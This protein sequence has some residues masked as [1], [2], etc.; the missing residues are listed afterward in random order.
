MLKEETNN[1]VE[2]QKRW[3][4][5]I[6]ENYLK[7]NKVFIDK[8]AIETI[9]ALGEDYVRLLQSRIIDFSESQEKSKAFPLGEKE[10]MVIL[11]KEEEPRKENEKVR[12]L[13][14]GNGKS[15]SDLSRDIADILKDKNILFYRPNSNQIVEVGKIKLHNKNENFYLGFRV[16]K[17][18]RFITLIEKYANVGIM[19]KGKFGEF[20]MTKS[21]SSI[22]ADIVLCSEIIEQALPQIE[23]VFSIPIPIMY[24]GEL[25]F[26]KKG[27]DER[28]NSWMNHNTPEINQDLDLEEA[29]KII[30]KV[31]SEFCFLTNQDK[32]NAIAG[33]LTPFLRGLFESFNTRTP[34][35]FFIANRE[36]IGKDYCAGVTGIVYD[37]QAIDDTPISSG[38]KYGGNNNEELR[39]KI[40]SALLSG[41][42]RMHF[43]N[44]KGFI[45]NAILEQVSTSKIYSDRL[46]GKNDIINIPNEMDFSLS[47]NLGVSYT[48]DLANRCLFVNLFLS[49]ENAN[50]REFKNPL[51]HEW[52]K[53]NRE[54]ILSALFSLVRNW[55]EKGRPKGSVAFASFPNWASICGGIMESA[56]YDNPYVQNKDTLAL[57]GDSDTSDMK[58]LFELCYKN[59]PLKAIKK[60]Q[61]VALINN[62][63]LFAEIDFGEKK[64]QI[65]FGLLLKRYVGRILSGI[66]LEVTNPSA[67]T[68]R[69]EYKFKKVDSK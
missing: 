62:E 33:L 34:I 68:S 44:N 56:G 4:E 19:I 69:H 13:L 46:L 21:L 31:F 1:L 9:I 24:N 11:E 7:K 20:F 50:S 5:D 14:D 63:E 15:I 17:D 65:N 45:N 27:F 10:V 36:R 53:E 32:I 64:G 28:F 25:T 37:G 61:I 16:I 41:R 60:N 42:K 22:K 57:V 3:L 49:M 51:L 58:Q 55:I 47:G 67:R 48:P 12:L 2:K 43:A 26:P 59:Y 39:K 30:D 18:K 52:V 29:K 23:R 40:T 54:I 8:T 6:Q 66:K 38:D 35:L